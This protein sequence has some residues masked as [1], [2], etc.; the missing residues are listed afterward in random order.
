MRPRTL[1]FFLS[2][3]N[4][5]WQHYQV[6]SVVILLFSIT[7]CLYG[8]NNDDY[9]YSNNVRNANNAFDK[10]D[11][12]RAL[13]LYMTALS[14]EYAPQ[15]NS[16]QDRIDLC[17]RMIQMR[18]A[19]VTVR[20]KPADAKVFLNKQK[21]G[22]TP[23]VLSLDTGMYKLKI[24][25]GKM[26]TRAYKQSLRIYSGGSVL[27]EPNLYTQSKS[28]SH[29][30]NDETGLWFTVDGSLNTSVGWDLGAHFGHQF[31]SVIGYYVTGQTNFSRDYWGVG[32]G[33]AL[34]PFPYAIENWA[35][36][37]GAGY[38]YFEIDSTHGTFRNHFD[39]TTGI[40]R[41]AMDGGLSLI[42]EVSM[43][44]PPGNFS[45]QT[46]GLSARVG[47]GWGFSE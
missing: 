36:T 37:I 14:C 43:Y 25:S 41:K 2:V 21:M 44:G 8:Q 42:F 35:W 13:M 27:I 39:F 16:V 29:S 5:F 40:V 32:A 33:I 45:D 9:C 20:S 38:R 3:T 46:I 4:Y 47:I 28:R 23:L 34:R 11:Y 6:L 10:G 12:E 26:H 17:N 15:D 22:N 7:V 30:M 19:T 18:T 1:S 24:R 31:N